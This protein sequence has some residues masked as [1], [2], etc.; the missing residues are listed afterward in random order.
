MFIFVFLH[1]PAF[2]FTDFIRSFSRYEVAKF[3]QKNSEI[4][5]I[6]KTRS[7]AHG[8][9]AIFETFSQTL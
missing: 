1:L 3:A 5:L 7:T 4:I 6:V 8:R 2:Y 9:S